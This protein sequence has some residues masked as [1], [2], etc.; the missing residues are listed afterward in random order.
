M[1]V[2]ARYVAVLWHHPGG[3][4]PL[5]DGLIARRM[6]TFLRY[7]GTEGEDEDAGNE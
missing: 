6:M 3:I 7:G 5:M 4:K 1:V 2:T